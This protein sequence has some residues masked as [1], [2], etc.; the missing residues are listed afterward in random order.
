LRALKPITAQDVSEVTARG[1]Y[2][3]H[4]DVPGYAE[5]LGEVPQAETFVALRAEVRNG[6]WSGVPFFIRTGKRLRA[7]MSEIALVFKPAAFHVFGA[8]AGAAAPNVLRFRLQPN[9]AVQQEI[10]I[11]DPGPGGMRLRQAVLDLS[12]SSD[13]GLG[14]GGLPDAYERLVLDVVRGDQTLFMRR[15]E[16]DAAWRWIDPIIEGWAERGMAPE[17]YDAGGSGPQGALRLIHRE[18]RAWRDIT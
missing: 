8:S 9:E 4:G 1:Q 15:D 18:G 2:R 5:E 3:G 6:R 16:V 10:T 17:Y 14:D 12:F 11:K 13:L 7:R